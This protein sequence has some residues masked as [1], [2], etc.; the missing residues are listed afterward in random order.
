[1]ELIWADHLLFFLLGVLMPWRM[2]Q[3]DQ[4]Q[5]LREMKFDTTL[6][7]A[8]YYGNSLYLWGLTAAVALL[9]YLTG[10]EWDL[11]GIGLNLGDWNWLS[12]VVAATFGLLYLGDAF[13][14]IWS[15]ENRREARAQLRTQMGFLPERGRE[16]LHYLV[17]AISAGFCEEFVFRAYFIR[18]FQVLFGSIDPSGTL[19]ICLSALVFGLAHAYQGWQTVIKISAMAVLFGFIFIHTGS[20]WI[21]VVIHAAVDIIGG[22]I[23]WW[24]LSAPTDLD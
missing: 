24:L 22:L 9:W 20:I 7:L 19:P 15:E 5:Q 16:F 10:R 17:L 6:K 8:L 21:L 12:L 14:E 3:S 4:I 2:L 1:M 23:A 13:S 18:Y 11:L